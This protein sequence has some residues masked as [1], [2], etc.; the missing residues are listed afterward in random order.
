MATEVVMPTLGLTMTEGTIEQWYVKEGDEV[1]SGDVLATISSEKLSGDVEAPEAGTVIKI[2][3]DEGDTL[4]CKAAMAYIGEA[5]EEVEV[6]DTEEAASE[7]EAESSSSKKDSPKEVNKDKTDT[8][9]R[10]GAVKG[11]RIFITPVA[12]KLAEEKGYNI[13]DIPGTGGNGRI[14]RR[15]VERYQPEAKPSQAVTSQA[16]EGLPGMRKT[17]AKRMVQSLQ[18]TAQLSLH[19]KADVTQLSKLR[20]EIKSKANDGAALGWTTLITR[21]AVKALEE[22]PEM[23]SWYQDGHW[24][25]HEAVHIGMATAVA[26]GLV[27]PVI[28]DAQGLSLSKL[29]EKINEVTSQAKAGQLPADLYSGSTFSITNMG[30]RGIEYFTPVIN[31][32]EAGILG[33]GAIQKEL[34]FDDNGEVVELSKFPLSLTFDHQLLDG[35]PAGA[36][37]DLI[38]SYLENPYSLLL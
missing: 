20:Q 12:R 8:K 18:T 26:D 37:L 17:I 28:R 15:D 1:S 34:A 36:F 9:A 4:K 22:T 30:G 5:G 19:R 32:P 6:E 25:Q 35:D 10:Q 29:G 21:A 27:V 16:G 24:E 14:T 2:L 13:E 38:V 23:N 3:A 7:T 11:D 31:P 33:L